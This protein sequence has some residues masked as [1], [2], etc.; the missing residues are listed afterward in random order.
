[1]SM[2]LKTSAEA[3]FLRVRVTGTFS[4]SEAKRTF[5]EIL[6][7]VAR[8]K[9]KKVLFDG[10]GIVGNPK[11]ME[12]FFYGEFVAETL[13]D[14]TVRGVS[15]TTRFAYVLEEPVLHPGRFGETV[16]FNRGMFIQA[17]A[18]ENHALAWLRIPPA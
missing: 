17:F 14:F 18:N 15:R 6:K 16:A 7:T 8:S 3:G 13:G 4:L 5:I 10:R 9:S 11:L 1:M 12:R 2:M